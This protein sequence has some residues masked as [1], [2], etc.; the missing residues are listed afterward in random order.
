LVTQFLA[1]PIAGK[2]DGADDAKAGHVTVIS[3]G[4]NSVIGDIVI[5]PIA[6][7]GFKAAGDALQ[8][9]APPAAPAPEDF[10]FVTGA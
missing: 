9:I 10:K 1:L 4:S 3:A 8:R 5:N 6:D 7:T 2:L